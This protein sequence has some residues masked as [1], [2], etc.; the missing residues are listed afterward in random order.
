MRLPAFLRGKGQVSALRKAK[1]VPCRLCKGRGMMWQP[2]GR[3]SEMA[4]LAFELCFKPFW[5]LHIVDSRMQAL[6]TSTCP[7]MPRV[8][9]D[10]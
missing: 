5:V 2:G 1:G 3:W 10:E 4:F 9:A 7:G 6:D 8:R